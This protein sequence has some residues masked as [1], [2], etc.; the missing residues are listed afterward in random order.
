MKKLLLSLLAIACL[1][2]S[3]FAQGEA[4]L[5]TA[6]KKLKNYRYD[7]AKNHD[8][9]LIAMEEISK[10]GAGEEIAKTAKYFVT[11]GQINKEMAADSAY[12]AQF[13]DAAL[14]AYNALSQ[15][16]GAADA[17]KFQI[18][19]SNNSLAE[20]IDPLIVSG[21]DVFEGGDYAS[22]FTKLSTA[23]KIDDIFL[24]AGEQGFLANDRKVEITYFAGLAARYGEMNEEALNTFTKMY[25]DG[26]GKDRPGVYE[27][28]FF[29][30]VEDNAEQAFKYLDE[31]REAH[32]TNMGLLIAK[33]NY[34]LGKDDLPGAEAALQEAIEKE[35]NNKTLYSAL[36]KVYDDI[37]NEASSEDMESGAD[38]Y[39]KAETYYKKAIELDGTFL[40]AVYN[41][42]AL[43]Y[44]KAVQIT[45][46]MNDLPYSETKKYDALK[47]DR[48]KLV[49]SALP[50]FLEAEAL[51]GND[52]NTI[53]AL[54]E[55]YA[56]FKDDIVKS[57]EYKEK[58]E[59][60]QRRGQ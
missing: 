22:A 9:L 11:L 28:M 8:D 49:D 18:K 52:V 14:N 29:L 43:Y 26:L 36:G 58:F 5:K 35:P 50:L 44:N 27:N 31:G 47:V 12:S 16:A 57:N 23:I 40:E 7:R 3:V 15:V 1:S 25:N 54:K 56:A 45:K 30:T 39:N 37:Y 24:D 33:I 41:L 34:M 19:E 2:A 20:L 51:D 46:V 10:V 38:A 4:S 6:D 17:K 21:A 53:I 48:D 32:P 42:G 55:I 13:P 59:A 60:L